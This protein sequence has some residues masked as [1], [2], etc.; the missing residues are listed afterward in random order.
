MID[1]FQLLTNIKRFYNDCVEYRVFFDYLNLKDQIHDDI[2]SVFSKDFSD[3][4]EIIFD[5]FFLKNRLLRASKASKFERF[6]FID[7]LK[8]IKFSS[9]ESFIDKNMSRSTASDSSSQSIIS[10]SSNEKISWSIFR[11]KWKTMIKSMQIMQVVFQATTAIIN[12]RESRR[13]EEATSNNSNDNTKW[14]AEKLRFF[15]SMYDNKSISIDQVM[16]HA[17]KNIYFRDVYLFLNR[18][19]DMTLIHEDQFVRK[20]L[21]IC[22]RDT[23]LQWYIA[24]ISIETKELLRY[25][26]SLR[27]WTEQFLK[28]FKKSF[29]VSII[30]ILK[31]R[32]VMKNARRHREFKKYASVILRTA[33]STK[34]GSVANQIAIIY[35]ELNVKF[36]R[37][38]IRSE[39]VTFLNVFL[40]KIDDFKH[41]WWSFATR[42]K[43]NQQFYNRYSA[44]YNQQYSSQI[45]ERFMKESTDNRR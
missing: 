12:I 37:N 27:Y 14:N 40:R 25:E 42:S 2:T 24:E 36:Q 5:K 31:E 43:F 19:K 8:S 18:V 13:F 16:K 3:F 4:V 30:T 10:V 17:E 39:N 23:A 29:D 32:Y 11:K 6:V 15:D 26:Q 34:L 38:L 35:N 28:R 22:L 9:L 1:R 21:F 7:S 20:N 45:A 33:K 44:N 41:I